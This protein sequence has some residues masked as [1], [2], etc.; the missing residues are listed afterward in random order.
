MLLVLKNKDTLNLDSF[1]FKCCVGK[2]G[3]NKFKKE[4]DGTTPVGT[5]GLGN[6]YY[7][8]DRVSKPITKF[9]CI[10]IKKNMGWC[11]DPNSKFYNKLIDIK[12]SANKEKMYRKDT[13]LVHP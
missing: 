5:F 3:L 4:G 7:R 1:S 6:I 2:K 10:K 8:S 13:G 12:S 11:D 9:N